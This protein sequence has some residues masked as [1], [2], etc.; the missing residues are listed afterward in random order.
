MTSKQQFRR[1]RVGSRCGNPLILLGLF[2]LWRRRR[3]A[4]RT[5]GYTCSLGWLSTLS[6]TAFFEFLE[7]RYALPRLMM[8]A[9]VLLRQQQG[10]LKLW[11]GFAPSMPKPPLGQVVFAYFGKRDVGSACGVIIT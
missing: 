10:L 1:S 11:I 4:K 9:I 8:I 7:W 3:L 2:G 6:F 5:L